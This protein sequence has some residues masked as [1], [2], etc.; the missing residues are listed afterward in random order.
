MWPG[1]ETRTLR[2]AAWASKPP[3]QRA[4]STSHLA[5]EERAGRRGTRPSAVCSCSLNYTSALA[6]STLGTQREPPK[7]AQEAMGYTSGLQ[8]EALGLKVLYVGGV[9]YLACLTLTPVV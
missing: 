2:Q 7:Q 3:W 1:T 6:P 8:I 5:K 9:S 4:A